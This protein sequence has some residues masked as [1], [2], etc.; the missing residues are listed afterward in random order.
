MFKNENNSQKQYMNYFSGQN[1]RVCLTIHPV[2]G[3]ARSGIRDVF[4]QGRAARTV[5]SSSRG[6]PIFPFDQLPEIL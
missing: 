4:I 5:G 3:S 2:D 6:I 1:M